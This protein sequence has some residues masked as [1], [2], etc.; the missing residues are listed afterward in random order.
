MISKKKIRTYKTIIE[1]VCREYNGAKEFIANKAKE[2]CLQEEI[3]AKEVS[4]T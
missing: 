1:E 3:S 2:L 4:K